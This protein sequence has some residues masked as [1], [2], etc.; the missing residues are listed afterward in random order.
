MLIY[1]KLIVSGFYLTLMDLNLCYIYSWRMSMVYNPNINGDMMGYKANVR[2]YPSVFKPGNV[3]NLLSIEVLICK[4]SSEMRAFPASCVW[5]RQGVP[6]L[7]QL[8]RGTCWWTNGWNVF[9]HVFNVF[10]SDKAANFMCRVDHRIHS[11]GD[12]MWFQHGPSKGSDGARQTAQ[13]VRR[14]AGVQRPQS[15]GGA[16]L[17]VKFFAFI[18]WCRRF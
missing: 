4:S 7:W 11:L 6:N 13:D 9:F 5:L 2:V 8:S 18:R 16:L 17:A 1:V 10:L 15:K 3:L 12:F 14:K